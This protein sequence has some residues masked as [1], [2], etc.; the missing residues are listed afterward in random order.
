MTQG[1]GELA[2]VGILQ[3]LAH[4]D[5]TDY[6]RFPQLNRKIFAVEKQ[7]SPVEKTVGAPAAYNTWHSFA[8]AFTGIQVSIWV[9][10]IHFYCCRCLDP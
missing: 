8:S 5:T 7:E 9:C 1:H 2:H 10:S 4:P 6:L 3:T